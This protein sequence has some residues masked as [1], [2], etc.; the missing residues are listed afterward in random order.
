MDIN[1]LIWMWSELPCTWEINTE[2]YIN[3]GVLCL[4]VTL[5]SEALGSEMLTGSLERRIQEPCIL[6]L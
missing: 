5:K 6:F 2:V 3:N 1:F 4:Q